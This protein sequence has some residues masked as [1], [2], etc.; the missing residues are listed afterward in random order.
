MVLT[1]PGPHQEVR[2]DP[3]PELVHRTTRT[4]RGCPRVQHRADP[5]GSRSSPSSWPGSIAAI[6]TNS[7]VGADLLPRRWRGARNQHRPLPRPDHRPDSQAVWLPP[8][9]SAPPARRSAGTTRPWSGSGTGSSNTFPVWTHLPVALNPLAVLGGGIEKT[10]PRPRYSSADCPVIHRHS[11][12]SS[13]IAPSGPATQTT[14]APPWTSE[15]YCS[16]LRL[17]C[18]SATAGALYGE[19]YA[20]TRHHRILL[21]LTANLLERSIIL[22]SRFDNY[23]TLFKQFL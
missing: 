7:L 10:Q 11:G 4:L 15:R 6:A 23:L 21:T 1:D 16:S 12:E 3:G 22:I 8:A 2:P 19:Q 20:A 13:L 14:W 18:S 9:R 5:A 17:I